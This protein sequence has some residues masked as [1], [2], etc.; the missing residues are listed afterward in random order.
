MILKLG[1]M[2]NLDHDLFIIILLLIIVIGMFNIIIS[3]FT[4]EEN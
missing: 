1:N 3:W 2:I 4:D